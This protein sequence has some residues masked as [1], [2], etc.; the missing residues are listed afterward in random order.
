MGC[1]TTLTF[2]GTFSVAYDP[3]TDGTL[4][5]VL[6]QSWSDQMQMVKHG[7]KFSKLHRAFRHLGSRFKHNNSF[8]GFGW[9]AGGTETMWNMSTVRQDLHLDNCFHRNESVFFQGYLQWSMTFMFR[10]IVEQLVHMLILPA[11]LQTHHV[12][13]H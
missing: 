10:P 11:S 3:G 7:V 9:T 5:V 12:M 1:P 6:N 13:I 4:D 2:D 8:S